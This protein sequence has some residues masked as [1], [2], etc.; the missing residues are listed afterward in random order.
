MKNKIFLCNAKILNNKFNLFFIH[1]ISQ[2][3]NAQ[4]TKFYSIKTQLVKKYI[5]VQISLLIKFLT[6]L[7]KRKISNIFVKLK[8][9]QTF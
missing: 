6:K 2:F 1:S 9:D 8:E 3:F 7:S 5:N 4:L